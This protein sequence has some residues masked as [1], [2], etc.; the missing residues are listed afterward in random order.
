MD[1]ATLRELTQRKMQGTNTRRCLKRYGVTTMPTVRARKRQILM[2]MKERNV[3]LLDSWTDGGRCA[4]V[5]A[6]AR[7]LSENHTTLIWCCQH[8]KI[9]RN[10]VGL[11][12]GDEDLLHEEAMELGS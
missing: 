1:N 9:L 7:E 8:E 12:E 3:K 2:L 4:S 10:Q 5:N 6:L 11:D